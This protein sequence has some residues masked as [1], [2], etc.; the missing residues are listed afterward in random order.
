MKNKVCK[1]KTNKI[2]EKDM[3]TY[4]NQNNDKKTSICTYLKFVIFFSKINQIIQNNLQL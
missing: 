1:R 4:I 2:D 3:K